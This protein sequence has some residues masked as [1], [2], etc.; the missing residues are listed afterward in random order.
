[1]A[2]LRSSREFI[3][4][5]YRRQFAGIVSLSR[6]ASSETIIRDGEIGE[7]SGVPQEHLK[8]KAY[9][10]RPARTASQ[11]GAS[12]TLQWKL[13]FDS[14]Q[15][16]ENPLMGWTSTGDPLAHVGDSALHFDS[17]EAALE[18]ARRH[19]W[20]TQVVEPHEMKKKVKAYAD[21]F[22]WKGP[23]PAETSG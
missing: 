22:R 10:Y 6:Y 13:R 21:N 9:V 8:R 23:A 17:K 5:L 20:E 14:T 18:F 1:M 19:G 15:K 11:Q 16:W 7:V 3:P 4:A 2:L 12:N